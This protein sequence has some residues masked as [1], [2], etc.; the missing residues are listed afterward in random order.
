LLSYNEH[1]PIRLN[2]IERIENLLISL[3]VSEVSIR[4]LL[5]YLVLTVSHYV[6]F[7]N[8]QNPLPFSSTRI[9]N[10]GI[11]KIFKAK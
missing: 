4:L 2:G 11:P 5:E 9:L 10:G 1:K 3:P 7:E 8:P 6:S